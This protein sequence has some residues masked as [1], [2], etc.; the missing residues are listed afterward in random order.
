MTILLKQGKVK[1]QIEAVQIW[2]TEKFPKILKKKGSI[3]IQVKKV[4]VKGT[5]FD[6]EQL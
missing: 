6:H 4:K 3:Y 5:N 2:P 1:H